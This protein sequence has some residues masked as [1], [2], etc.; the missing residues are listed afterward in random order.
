[1]LRDARRPRCA[2][3]AGRFVSLSRDRDAR[4]PAT[5]WTAAA[6]PRSRR[7]RRRCQHPRRDDLRH[8]SSPRHVGDH[9]RRDGR[10]SPIGRW[11]GKL[12]VDAAARRGAAG[13]TCPE[14]WRV[15]GPLSADA[16][17]GGTFDDYTLDTTITGTRADVGGPVDRSRH[18][19]G[20]GH[21]RRDR[22][23]ARS[24]CTRAPGFST[25]AFATRGRPAPTPPA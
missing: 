3:D 4:S 17:L 25:A 24:N 16:I 15:T 18:R 20:D 2:D 7:R 9:R 14:A 21:R 12:H 13:T 19:Q 1:M 22:R 23:D 6:W 8:R 11:T 10:T 5:R